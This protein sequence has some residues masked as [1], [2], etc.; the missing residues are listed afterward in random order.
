M[1]IEVTTVMEDGDAVMAAWEARG[2]HEGTFRGIE[3]TG[4]E[5]DVRGFSYRR[6]AAG[7]FVAATDQVGMM[8]MLAQ[9]GVDLPLQG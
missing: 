7:R 8:T 9:L 2:T 5:I 1:E 3:P 6:A 4:R